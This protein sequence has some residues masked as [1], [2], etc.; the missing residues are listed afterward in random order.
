[1]AKTTNTDLLMIRVYYED[2]DFSGN[3][4]HAQYLKFFERGRTEY[5]RARGVHHA[6]LAKDS[7][8]FAV[9]HMELFFDAAAHIDDVL[10]VE[11]RVGVLSG[12]RVVLDQA[13]RRDGTIAARAEVTVAMLNARGRPVRIPTAIRA[14][15]TD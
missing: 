13:M 1:M 5:L 7:L 8:V 3:V 14:A 6:E 9:T 10:T 4:Y 11:T 12:A 15:L 2:T